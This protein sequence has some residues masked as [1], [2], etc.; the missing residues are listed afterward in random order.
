MI[1]VALDHAEYAE[2]REMAGHAGR[3]QRIGDVHAV[4]VEM[5]FLLI[6]GNENLQ[7]PFRDIAER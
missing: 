7:R 4:A 2:R 1:A 3:D 5:Q 6:D